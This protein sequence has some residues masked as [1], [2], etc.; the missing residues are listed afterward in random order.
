MKKI[1]R[2]ST[3]TLTIIS[4]LAWIFLILNGCDNP[5]LL[6]FITLL[7]MVSMFSFC[8]Q[9]IKENKKYF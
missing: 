2:R 3:Y 4:Y 9:F 1:N 8:Y 5:K 7:G 6:S